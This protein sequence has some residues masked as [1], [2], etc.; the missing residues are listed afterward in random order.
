M[1]ISS[2]V[3]KK[4]VE[5]LWS[6]DRRR[7]RAKTLMY[8]ITQKV[9]KVSTPNVLVAHHDKMQLQGKEHNSESCSFATFL[10]LSRM[11]APDEHWY[12]MRCSCFTCKYM[13]HCAL[14][15]SGQGNVHF[16][17]NMII[18]TKSHKRDRYVRISNCNLLLCSTLH[19]ISIY[20]VWD[21]TPDI[22][23]FLSHNNIEKKY[24]R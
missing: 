23:A 1:H 16:T 14:A 17:G 9:L 21:R 5:L 8:P 11:M 24:V 15:E 3:S 13:Y 7:C 18:W 2:C 19:Y 22:N 20:T 4:K 6:L 10:I 12:R